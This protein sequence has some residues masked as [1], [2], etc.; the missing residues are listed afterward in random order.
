[1]KTKSE[2]LR[3]PEAPVD[4][5]NTFHVREEKAGVGHT[6][7]HVSDANHATSFSQPVMEHH[8]PGTQSLAK[9]TQTDAHEEK[10]SGHMPGTLRR[11]CMQFVEPIQASFSRHRS[12]ILAG[13]LQCEELMPLLMKQR[14][15]RSWTAHDRTQIHTGLK[16]LADASVL[17]II[18]LMPGSL[19]LLPLLAWWL[20][21][22]KQKRPA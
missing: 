13:V 3:L 17:L 14:N 12:E 22:R 16:V 20:D 7:G 11:L 2:D 10:K 4:S 6:S 1:M 18:F 15:G 21:R 9:D 19:V 5:C 8:T